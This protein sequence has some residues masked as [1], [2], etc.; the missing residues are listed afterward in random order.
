MTNSLFSL[1]GIIGALSSGFLA[2][3]FGRKNGIFFAN[4]FVLIASALNIMSK[5]IPSYETLM[6]GRFFTGIFSGIFSGLVPVGKKNIGFDFINLNK[7][8]KV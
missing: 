8:G 7:K 6:T 2:D 5:F 4:I 3:F 1:G